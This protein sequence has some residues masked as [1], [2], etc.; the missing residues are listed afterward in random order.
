MRYITIRIVW[1]NEPDVLQCLRANAD[2]LGVD[3]EGIAK[4]PNGEW[5]MLK[6]IYDFIKKHI[7][8]RPK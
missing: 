7:R 4:T 3:L 8:S 6:E 2:L 5:V 1:T